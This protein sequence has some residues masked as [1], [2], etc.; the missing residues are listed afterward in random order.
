MEQDLPEI[1]SQQEALRIEVSEA[2]KVLPEQSKAKF[3]NKDDNVDTFASVTA[4]KPP[5]VLSPGIPA[6]PPAVKPAPSEV[7]QKNFLLNGKRQ[8][9]TC[10]RLHPSQC[11]LQS[12]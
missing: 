6:A 12:D 11:K 8:Y 9:V 2:L 5:P 4:P 7:R 1:K 3:E 10:R